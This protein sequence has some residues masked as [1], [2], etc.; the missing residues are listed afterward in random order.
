[1]ENFKVVFDSRL[2]ES[3][4]D[5]GRMSSI[6][7]NNMMPFLRIAFQCKKNETIV[8]ITVSATGIKAK[9]EFIKTSDE[10]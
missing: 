2:K 8:G 6:D 4:L 3:D 9:I 1:M 10:S 7:W 5:F